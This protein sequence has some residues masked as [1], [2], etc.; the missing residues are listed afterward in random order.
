M[1]KKS[2]TNSVFVKT[3]LI[4]RGKVST[5]KLLAKAIGNQKAARAAGN[6]LNK[7]RDPKVPCHR[8]ARSDGAI[9]GFRDGA[10]A[11]IKILRKEGVN[12]IS[13]K[14]SLKKYLYEF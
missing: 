5:Y 10:A 7:N 12:I 6:A 9:G 8:V 1:S 4:P 13:D 2:F 3:K 11:K 14:I